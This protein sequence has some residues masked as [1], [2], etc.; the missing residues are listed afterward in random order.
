M[1]RELRDYQLTSQDNGAGFI[2][3]IGSILLNYIDAFM[4]IY[5]TYGPHF[6]LAEYA[7]KK[8]MKTNILFQNFIREKEKQAETRK[9]PFR[10]YIILPITRLQ[11]YPLLLDAILRRTTDEHERG[12]LK[13]CIARIKAVA[14]KMDDLTSDMKQ[15]LHLRQIHDKVQFKP[16]KRYHLDLL[17]PGRRLVYEGP[18]KRRA[19][20]DSV[21]L[22][23]FLFD[24]LL[25]MT[26]P[27]RDAAGKVETYM[28]SKNPIPL[29]LLVVSDV[30]EGLFTSFRS[31][32]KT[33]TN[34]SLPPTPV[35]HHQ[36]SLMVRHLGRH[37]GEYVLVAETQSARMAWKDKIVSTQ[38][39]LAR[40]EHERDVF[41]VTTISDT[42]FALSGTLNNNGKVTC[43]A[44]FGKKTSLCVC[45]YVDVFCYVVGSSG[46]KM[47]V[48]GTQQ[49]V[50]IGKE[51]ETNG[52]RK[53][54]KL[55]DVTQIDVLE[56]NHVLLVLA[57]M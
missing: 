35:L 46:D 57:G 30:A 53:V 44:S 38:K 37:G 56:P 29:S 23:V 9:L 19:H 28:V 51:N 14:S 5:T 4:D 11:R 15:L 3:K 13:T 21:E 20:I 43:A 54:I 33:G 26:K 55:S 42:L 39:S 16:N 34:A 18:M 8:E 7:A 6:I 52:L 17:K 36:S 1:Y 49:G 50:W 25:L 45:A 22:Y 40:K 24:H 47:V 27:K 31:T 48:V 2:D 41:K 32:A 12:H 10:H